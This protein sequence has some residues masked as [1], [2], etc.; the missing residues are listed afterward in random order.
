MMRSKTNGQGALFD[1]KR[2]PHRLVP[3]LGLTSRFAGIFYT[4]MWFAVATQSKN[5]NM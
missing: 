4:A 5:E 1:Q 2:T 3:F